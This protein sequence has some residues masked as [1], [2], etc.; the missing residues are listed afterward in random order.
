MNA[1]VQLASIK[2][3]IKIKE[4]G[5]FLFGKKVKSGVG[6]FENYMEHFLFT[7]L[8]KKINP[9]LTRKHSD[10]YWYL[11]VLMK[12]LQQLFF[13]V[14][15]MPHSHTDPGWLQTV[16]GYFATSTK[17]IISNVVNKLTQHTN[18]T[19]IWSEASYMFMWWDAA[20]QEDR[21]NIHY[22]IFVIR[23]QSRLKDLINNIFV[24]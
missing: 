23:F 14:I 5:K 22:F 21:S 7:L 3:G 4:K 10:R 13:R 12:A 6:R 16:E 18:M 2:K 17:S 9:A 1:Y 24:F 19:F 11:C 20:N 8:W 15:V